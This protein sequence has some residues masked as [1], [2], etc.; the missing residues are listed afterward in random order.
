MAR[1]DL[2]IFYDQ[3]NTLL[4]ATSRFLESGEP[5]NS[6]ASIRNLDLHINEIDKKILKAKIRQKHLISSILAAYLKTNGYSLKTWKYFEE[7]IYPVLKREYPEYFQYADIKNIRGDILESTIVIIINF[8]FI[9]DDIRAYSL[10]SSRSSGFKIVSMGTFADKLDNETE[11]KIIKK[12][13]NQFKITG[14]PVK[15]IWGD[16]DIII[17]SKKVPIDCFCV[18]SCKS[19]LRERAF[20]SA[21]WA[22]RSRLEGKYRHVFCT[23]DYGNSEGNTEIGFRKEKNNSAKKNRD[24]L[25]SIMDRSYV[26]R[27][28]DEVPR[29]HS[30]KDLDY[31]RIDLERWEADFWGL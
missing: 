2:T 11:N 15:S 1:Q 27:N 3:C 23:L 20:Q 18:I 25:E 26:F 6:N 30:I 17:I 10:S 8:I 21:F 22:M 31:L 4:Q 24:V 5:L 7:N 14:I 28:E 16:N 29:S 19:S 13:H 12:L 9:I